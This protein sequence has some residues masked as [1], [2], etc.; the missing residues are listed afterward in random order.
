MEHSQLLGDL[1]LLF[2]AALAGGMLAHLLR[3]PLVVGYI[4]GGVMVSPF[5]P[6]PR[7]TSPHSFAVFADIGVILL[8]FALGAE[9]SIRELLQVR[10]VA[11]YGAPVG[12]AL[13]VVVTAL[14]TRAAG[15]PWPQSIAVGA[16]MSVSSSMVLLKFLQD[17]RELTSPHGRVVIGIAVFQDVAAVAMIMLLPAL[18]A[19]GSSDLVTLGLVMAKA[20]AIL[21]PFFWLARRVVPVVLARVAGTRNMELFVLVAMVMAMGTATLTSAAGL[22]PALGA[23]LAGLL[24]SE[25]EV[26][27]ETLARTLPIRDIFVAVF[28]TS[29]GMLVR[30]DALATEVPTIVML[31]MLVVVVNFVIWL[32]TV[33]SAG[34]RGRT[35][36]LAALALTQ[37][38]EFSYVLAAESARRGV[39]GA[40]TYQAVLATSIV[41][42]VIN[43]LLFRRTPAWLDALLARLGTPG[44][45]PAAAAPAGGHVVLC[46]FGRMGQAVAE[47]LRRAGIP[48][49]VVDLDPDAIEVAKD[50]RIPAIYGDAGSEAALRYAGA[51][52][53]RL[54]VVTIP[55]VRPAEQCIRALR[56]LSAGLPILAR[57]HHARDRV[58]LLAAG[59]TDVVQPE[60]EGALTLAR[61]SLGH[62]RAPRHGVAREA[63]VTAADMAVDTVVSASEEAL[64][65]E[66][67]T[68]LNPD[69]A[70]RSL[71]E[72]HLEQR[73]GARIARVVRGGARDAVDPTPGERLET[74]DRLWALGTGEELAALRRLCEGE[75]TEGGR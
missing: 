6:G 5:T 13:I 42:V 50:R 21:A 30:P 67:I 16:A 27:H 58:H 46:G 17:R 62:L 34:Y 71:A 28:F 74:G 75:A 10:R 49:V 51:D 25:S 69:V 57:A 60:V 8:M 54:A 2:L 24:V 66:E 7:V 70:G 41:T 31:V 19:P 63:P 52:R 53:A 59:A 64:G 33:G 15:W 44:R 14:V 55:H 73:T 12:I 39:I 26:A 40:G 48:C 18:K 20:G 22:S 23:F 9:F 45:V 61:R 68:V 72:A 56:L 32:G 65:V 38:G 36:V 1:G 47:T 29:I 37:I 11:L 35:A 3:Q 4:L 43:A